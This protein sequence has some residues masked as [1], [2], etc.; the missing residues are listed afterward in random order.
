MTR[1]AMPLALMLALL[2]LPAAGS[3]QQGAE[4]PEPIKDNSFLVE[5][6]YNQEPGVVQHVNTFGRAFTGGGWEYS[7]TQ[8][9]PVRS[10][11]H[12]LSVTIPVAQVTPGTRG[13]IGD[14]LLNYRYQLAGAEGGPIAI[15]PRAS[16]VLPTGSTATGQGGGGTGLQVNLPLSLEHGS[17]FV[18]HWNAGASWTPAARDASGATASATSMAASQSV[19]WLAHERVNLLVETAWT[20]AAAVSG[21]NTTVA[22]HEAFVAPG[23]RWKHD[24]RSGLQVVPGIAIPIG[25]G[26]ARGSR[27]LFVYLSFEHPY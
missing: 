18:T 17:R 19:I 23:V 26:P 7:F 10:M 15:A 27:A 9:W 4:R 8:E 20:R 22:V 2:A 5:E 16:L 3:A 25:V 12:Q 21:P 14:V 6:A 24:F 13:S 11:R 1:L